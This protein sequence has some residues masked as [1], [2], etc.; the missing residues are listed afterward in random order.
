M[1]SNAN[2]RNDVL[3]TL[4]MDIIVLRTHPPSLPIQDCKENNAKAA[5]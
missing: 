4:Q 3:V 2:E 1:D 5:D